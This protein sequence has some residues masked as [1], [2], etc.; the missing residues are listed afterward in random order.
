MCLAREQHFSGV[1]TF[2]PQ[3][4]PVRQDEK[5]DSEKLCNLPRVT[6]LLSGRAKT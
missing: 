2:S 6:Q 5:T 3:N 4:G 1:T